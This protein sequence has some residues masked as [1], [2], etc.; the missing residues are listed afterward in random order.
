[1]KKNILIFLLKKKINSKLEEKINNCVELKVY[2][3]DSKNLENKINRKRK[4]Y[5]KVMIKNL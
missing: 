1:M 5:E 2:N 3:Q 4:I